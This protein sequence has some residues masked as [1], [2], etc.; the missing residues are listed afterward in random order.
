[1]I[2]ESRG[3]DNGRQDIF[4]ACDNESSAVARA[5]FPRPV[6]NHDDPLARRPCFGRY[7]IRLLQA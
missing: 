2:A 5:F 7:I 3:A 1:M 6:R 4:R